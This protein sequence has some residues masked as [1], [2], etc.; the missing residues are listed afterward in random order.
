MIQRRVLL[1]LLAATGLYP[2]TARAQ[3]DRA[4]AFI[5]STGDR[6]VTI[7]NAGGSTADK[8]REIGKIVLAAIDVETVGRFCLGRFWRQAS[9]EQQKTYQ[10]LFQEVLITSITAKL[11]EYQG[12]RFTMGRTRAQEEDQIVATVVERPNN[13]PATVEWVVA[14]AATDPKVVDV[15]AEGTS[16]RITQRSDYASFLSRNNNSIDALLAAMRRQIEAG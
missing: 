15:I 10:A 16:L 7:V 11:G 9:A 1:S 5:K 2:A 13:A 8:R 12:V 14:R 6:L 3:A 4:S